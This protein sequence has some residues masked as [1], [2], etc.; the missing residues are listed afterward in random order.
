MIEKNKIYNLDC[1]QGMQE[2]EPA[3]VDAI[4]CDLPYGTTANPWDVLIPWEGLWEQY[5]RIIKP[6]GVICLFAQMPFTADVV[7]SNRKMFRYMWTWLKDNVTGV[8]NCNKM[9]LKI[10]ENICIFYKKLP[11]YNPQMLKGQA[12]KVAGKLSGSVNYKYGSSFNNGKRV[13]ERYTDE[14]FPH[15]LI[16]F[17]RDAQKM[18]PTQKPV[19]LLRYLVRTY[20]NAGDLVLDNCMGSGT[21]AVACIMEKRDFIGFELNEEYYNKALA[22]IKVAEAY[23]KA[24]LFS[25]E[26]TND[27]F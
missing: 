20:T 12:H 19:D 6:N 5:N 25:D 10:T 7:N 26:E 1:L 27:L 14:Y 9:P 11:T 4:I 18:H 15:D 24:T 3:S 16:Y 8:A 2:I 21:T 13:P 22:R 23:E 17:P